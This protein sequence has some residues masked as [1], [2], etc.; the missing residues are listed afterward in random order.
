M[1]LIHIVARL[2]QT[3]LALTIVFASGFVFQ[4]GLVH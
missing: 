2:A 4:L 1:N 3:L